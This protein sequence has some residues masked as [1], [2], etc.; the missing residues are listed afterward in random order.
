M[1]PTNAIPAALLPPHRSAR[2]RRQIHLPRGPLRYVLLVLLAGAFALAGALLG[3]WGNPG[4]R[5]VAAP[6]AAPPPV[7]AVAPDTAGAEGSPAAGG[8]DA[9]VGSSTAPPVPHAAAAPLAYLPEAVSMGARRALNSVASAIV[10]AP[11][12]FP[13]YQSHCTRIMPMLAS[14]AGSVMAGNFRDADGACYVWIN[15]ST[16][17]GITGAALCKLSLHELGHLGGYTHVADVADVMH[18]PFVP[19]PIPPACAQQPA[20]LRAASKAGG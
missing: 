10:L 12:A 3:G 13:G 15:L 11:R 4:P 20:A 6:V 7:I 2:E 8:S 1:A 14:V 18:A 5:A 16:T 19:T 17:A 9:G